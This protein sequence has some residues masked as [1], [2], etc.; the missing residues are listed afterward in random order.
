MKTSNEKNLEEFEWLA[1]NLIEHRPKTAHTVV[2]PDDE[3]L[4][5]SY[6]TMD[7]ITIENRDI[8]YNRILSFADHP[9][10]VKSIP[11]H[12]KANILPKEK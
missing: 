9:I 6:H 2:W 5:K 7:L 12:L 3:M 10:K 11:G 8:I 1:S 4:K